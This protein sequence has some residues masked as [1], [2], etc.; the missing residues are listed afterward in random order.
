MIIRSS[1]ASIVVIAL[2]IVVLLTPQHIYKT[3]SATILGSPNTSVGVPVSVYNIVIEGVVSGT[4]FQRTGQLLVTHQP[5]SQVTASN[6]FDILLVSGD[7]WG[8]PDTGS[9][10]F[11]SNSAMVGQAHV[12]L[13][14]QIHVPLATVIADPATGV[15]IART[16]PDFAV[17]SGGANGFNAHSGFI[18]P[19]YF[20][21]YGEMQMQ[22]LDRWQTITGI[23]EALGSS[24][25]FNPTTP[26]Q[27][28]FAG[29]YAGE[30]TI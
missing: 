7:P 6:L 2:F 13:V 23:I 21:M 1:C 4:P 26:Y 11:T 17:H 3:A 20:I 19:F 15:I 24:E 22:T 16:Q 5:V 28:Q 25:A 10:Q 9:I 8:F 30:G 14:G 27:A 18:A 29:T 12:P